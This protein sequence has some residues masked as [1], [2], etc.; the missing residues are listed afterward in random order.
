MSTLRDVAK[1]AGVSVTT[2]SIVA[3]GKS[4]ERRIS[5]ETTQKVM[6]AMQQLQYRPN[7]TAR[8]LRERAA[9]HPIIGFYWPL[10]YRTNLLGSR[11]SNLNSVLLEDQLGYELVV[12]TYINNRIE[13]FI[14]PVLKGRYDGVIIGAASERD[15]AQ[16]TQ[17]DI[18]VPVIL[19]NR[20]SNKYSTVGANNSQMGMQVAALLQQKGYRKCAVVKTIDRYMGATGRTKAFLYACRQLKI[21]ILPEWMFSGNNTITGGAEATEEYC[22]LS[23]RPNVIFYEA[24]CMAQGGLFTLQRMGLSVPD[25]VEII[26]IGIQASETMQYLNPPISCVSIPSNVDRLAMSTMARIL[27]ERPSEPLHVELEPLVQ[28]RGSFIL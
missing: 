8:L 21:E 23:N 12:Q 11:L 3:T 5:P 18:S 4:E 19:L 2:A 13:D 28:L 9:S 6:T 26:S 27:K 20:D 1:L 7:Q 16:L 17:L 25:D 10:D 15:L 24:D 22:A 14:G